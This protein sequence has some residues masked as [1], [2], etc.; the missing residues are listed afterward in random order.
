M[1]EKDKEEH[2]EQYQRTKEIFKYV[3]P[4][5]VEK[6]KELEDKGIICSSEVITKEELIY[7]TWKLEDLLNLAEKDDYLTDFINSRFDIKFN[8]EIN[9]IEVQKY[10][11][12]DDIENLYKKDNIVY[13]KREVDINYVLGGIICDINYENNSFWVY[14]SYWNK[15]L[16]DNILLPKNLKTIG[17]KLQEKILQKY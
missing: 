10:I 4:K 13:I 1:S 16:L 14:N 12:N 9:I 2:E 17:Q 15:D 6:Y 3:L 7:D 8:K 11:Y 5:V